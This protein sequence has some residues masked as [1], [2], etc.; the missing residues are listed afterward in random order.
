MG[1]CIEYL[2]GLIFILDR[3]T[4]PTDSDKKQYHASDLLANPNLTDHKPAHRHSTVTPS[5]SE[6]QIQLSSCSP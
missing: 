4:M 5:C 1:T 6:A 2:E 3:Q